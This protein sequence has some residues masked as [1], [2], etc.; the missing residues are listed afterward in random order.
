MPCGELRQQRGYH[1]QS[2][3]PLN[4]CDRGIFPGQV[5]VTLVVTGGVEPLTFR[6]ASGGGTPW[7]LAPD[8][9]RAILVV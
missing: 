2:R 5:A 3:M 8:G 7:A 4:G 9:L 1:G 6:V